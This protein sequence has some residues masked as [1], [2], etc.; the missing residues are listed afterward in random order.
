MRRKEESGI[1]CASALPAPAP[2][3]SG[4][5]G[6]MRTRR[7]SACTIGCTFFRKRSRQMF[8]RARRNHMHSGHITSRSLKCLEKTISDGD[9]SFHG[10]GTQLRVYLSENIISG[11][12]QTYSSA[13]STTVNGV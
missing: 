9:Q 4:K 11:G 2:F 12:R 3:I 10:F 8:Q 5:I 1:S 6:K 13:T 7:W